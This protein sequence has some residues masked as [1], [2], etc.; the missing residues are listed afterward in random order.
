MM[1]GSQSHKIPLITITIPNDLAICK[2]CRGLADLTYQ[3]TTG[4]DGQEVSYQFFKCLFSPSQNQLDYVTLRSAS[5]SIGF[6]I[7]YLNRKLG[8]QG[9]RERVG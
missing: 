6:V 4:L 2:H 7:R 9:V 5:E 8:G 1:S 3:Y